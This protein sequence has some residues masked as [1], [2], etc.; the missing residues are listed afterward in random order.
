MSLHQF[1]LVNI[2]VSI[3]WTHLLH[4]NKPPWKAILY[5]HKNNKYELINVL[6]LHNAQNLGHA[7]YEGRI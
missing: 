4:E 1:K 5:K 7:K 2:A 3:G 6:L